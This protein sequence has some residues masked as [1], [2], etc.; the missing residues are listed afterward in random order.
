MSPSFEFKLESELHSDGLRV[1]K[2][3]ED[4]TYVFVPKA[5][6]LMPTPSP[7][8]GW[9]AKPTPVPAPRTMVR[10]FRGSKCVAGHCVPTTVV[11]NAAN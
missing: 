4:G 11:N 6:T 9:T 8:P 10:V 1:E 7:V 5:P 3:L 2:V